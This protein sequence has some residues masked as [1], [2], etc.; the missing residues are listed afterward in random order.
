MV[1]DQSKTVYVALIR[2]A[3]SSAHINLLS[4]AQELG[5]VI[6]G[7]YTYKSSN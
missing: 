6:V 7:I 2:D 1:T 5:R 3:I 4:K